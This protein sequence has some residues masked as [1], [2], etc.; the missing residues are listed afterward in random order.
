[1]R[2]GDDAKLVER[3]VESLNASTHDL[4][5]LTRAR[6]GAARRRAVAAAGARRRPRRGAW[7]LAG[8]ALSLA[9]IAVVLVDGQQETWHPEG[10]TTMA[11]LAALDE[12]IE[13]YEDLEFYVWLSEQQADG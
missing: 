4:D 6:L 5:E 3:V 10:L 9:V 7:A 11:E 2:S 12:G 8:A 13:L 1:M